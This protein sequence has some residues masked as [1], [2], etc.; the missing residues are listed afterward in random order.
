MRFP[1]LIKLKS[2]ATKKYC[3][4]YITIFI[5]MADCNYTYSLLI[6]TDWEEF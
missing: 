2:Q 1:A 3:P 6:M 4:I 5:S